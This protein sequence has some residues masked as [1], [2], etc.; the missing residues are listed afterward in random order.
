MGLIF[1]ER[2]EQEKAVNH[3]QKAAEIWQEADE[4]FEPAKE[5]KKLLEQLLGK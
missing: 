3:L 4:I 1:M 2:E 5:N